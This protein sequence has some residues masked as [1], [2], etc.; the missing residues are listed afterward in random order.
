MDEMWKKIIK[1]K[2]TK[3]RRKERLLERE[4]IWRK[5]VRMKAI[6]KWQLDIKAHLESNILLNK[7]QQTFYLR[8][9][10]CEA[11]GRCHENVRG[12]K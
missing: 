11:K 3:E 5:K 1:E 8:T 6:W 10:N 2:K 7:A 12:I 9:A 4:K